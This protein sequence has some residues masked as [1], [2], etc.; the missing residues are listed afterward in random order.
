ME[1]LRKEWRN[2]GEGRVEILSKEIMVRVEWRD[3]G[4]GGVERLW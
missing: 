4:E 1:R 2:Y 3:C